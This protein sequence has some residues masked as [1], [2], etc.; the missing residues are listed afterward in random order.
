VV[1]A[2]YDTIAV[3]NSEGDFVPYLAE[4]IEPNADFT[5]WTITLR[6]G[7]TFHN[8]EPL[9]AEAVKLNLDTY[10]GEPGSPQGAPL[11]TSVQEEFWGGSEV[12]DDLTLKVTMLKP[13][14]GYPGFLYGT[15]RA[16]IMAPE[17]L[18]AGEECATRMIGTGPFVCNG[19]C[20]VPGE[21]LTVEANPDYWQEGYPK[22]DR[23]VFQ[24]VPDNSDRA[25]ALR[26]DELDIAHVDNAPTLDRIERQGSLDMKV[27]PVGVREVR[28]YF[29]NAAQPPF[30]ELDARLAVA[31]AIDRDEVNQVINKGLFQITGGIM[32]RD[33]PGYLKDA[34]IP[35][36]NLKKAKELAE[37][38][39]AANN[40]EFSVR[41]LAD[42]SD[43]SN[44]DEAQLLQQQ[45]EA[46]GIDTELPPAANQASFITDAVAG[47][48]G[49]F[50]WRNLHG[51]NDKYIDVDMF[52]WFGEKSLVNFGRISD[53]TLEQALNDGREAEDIADLK[54]A[55]KTA[56]RQI[57]ENVYILP[58]WYVDWTIVSTKDTKV[59]LPNLPDGGGK[60]L[61]VYGRIPLLGLSKT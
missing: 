18:N 30:D 7:I 47:N 22:A 19:E 52:P 40:G 33:A 42:T 59:T 61:F 10:A 12:V 38:V 27:Q 8:G 11:F 21:S 48:F 54:E 57:S 15:G 20:W 56:N 60:P 29:L 6:E 46:A 49:M 17:Q 3:P 4:S 51:G 41:I 58:M 39:K 1:A 55:Y 32:D 23:I 37:K 26:G 45:L 25:N 43:P 31:H 13:F 44:I 34:G 2:V 50:L 16:G 36:F 53:A 35:E 14:P 9:N 5:E 28:Y 24:P